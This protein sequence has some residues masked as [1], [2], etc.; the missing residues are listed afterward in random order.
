MP[1]D[2]AL[3]LAEAVIECGD[4]VLGS[5]ISWAIVGIAQHR[6]CKRT[7]LG[8]VRRAHGATPAAQTIVG[9]VFDNAGEA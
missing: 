2:A 6:W 1:V 5:R 3:R 8:D 9:L 4:F 7:G